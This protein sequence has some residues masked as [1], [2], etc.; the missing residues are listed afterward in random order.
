MG[1]SR[2]DSLKALEKFDYNA[3]KSIDFL[4]S[5]AQ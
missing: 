4:T 1:F 2:D 5:R 3:D